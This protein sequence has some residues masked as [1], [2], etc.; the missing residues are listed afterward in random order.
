MDMSEFDIVSIGWSY[1]LLVKNLFALGKK[2]NVTPSL[3]EQEL[4]P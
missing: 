1:D 3:N 2:R 4:C